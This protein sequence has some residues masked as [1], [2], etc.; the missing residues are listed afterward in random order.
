MVSFVIVLLQ[1]QKITPI[2][3]ILV[4]FYVRKIVKYFTKTI[5]QPFLI[6]GKII[7]RRYPQRTPSLRVFCRTG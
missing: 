5:K 1:F 4:T 6:F 2:K 7:S 3:K